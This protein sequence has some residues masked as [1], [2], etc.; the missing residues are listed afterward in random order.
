MKLSIKTQVMELTYE[1]EYS[2]IEEDIKKRI[3][4]IIHSIP[5]PNPIG[6]IDGSKI[7]G[8]AN[9]LT[10]SHGTNVPLTYNQH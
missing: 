6:I 3:I 8:I 2:R 10:Q 5:I 4:E 1:D 9:A 7:P